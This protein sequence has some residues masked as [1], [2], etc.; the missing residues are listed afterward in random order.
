MRTS[1]EQRLTAQ[2][3]DLTYTLRAVADY[4]LHNPLDM[5]TRPLRSV[6]QASGSSPAAF[7][8]LSKALGYTGLDELR[9]ELREKIDQRMSNFASRAEK[10]QQDHGAGKPD[11]MAAHLAACQANLQSLPESIDPATLSQAVDVLAR[12]RMVYLLG[13]LGST[14]IVEYMAYMA[15]M[16]T[17]NWQLLGR[18]GASLG[19]G[20]TNMSDQD[21]LVIV[22]KPPFAPQAIKAAEIARR[23]GAHVVVITDTHACP[24][25][26]HAQFGFVLPS[27]SPHFYSSYVTTMFLVE[28]MIGKLVSRAGE[29]ARLRIANV[30]DSNRLLSEVL[31]EDSM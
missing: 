16:C 11:F 7:T 23:Q 30:E 31:D 4:I 15:N 9:E 6:A 12:S 25:L 28:V 10:L 27:T 22:T 29:N 18:M 24:A 3:G 20:L 21:A 17:G 13:A 1:F 8:R 5:A 26:R 14:G 19:S 2:Y